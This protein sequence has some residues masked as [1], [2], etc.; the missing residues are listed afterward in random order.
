[1]SNKVLTDENTKVICCDKC[2]YWYCIKCANTPEAGYVF[3]ASKEAEAVTWY[4]RPCKLPAKTTV[5]EG[6]S[7]EDKCKEYM[8]RINQRIKSIE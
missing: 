6:K 2:E 7:I 4:C 8:E 3:L 1:M 5:L